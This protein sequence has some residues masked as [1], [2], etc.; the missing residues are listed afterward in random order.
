MSTRGSHLHDRNR[1][2]PPLCQFIKQLKTHLM[3][4][5]PMKTSLPGNAAVLSALTI[6]SFRKWYQILNFH[7]LVLDLAEGIFVYKSFKMKWNIKSYFHRIL[8]FSTASL[9]AWF[10]YKMKMLVLEHGKFK[11][12]IHW[13]KFL[14]MLKICL[15]VQIYLGVTWSRT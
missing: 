7:I 9:V 1:E 5:K 14:R 10:P 15:D 8:L 4:W 11:K 2:S 3:R 6:F 12:L 13:F